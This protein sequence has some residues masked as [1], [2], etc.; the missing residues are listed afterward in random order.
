MKILL[1]EDNVKL[2]NSIQKRLALKNYQVDAF[3]DGKKAHDS[4]ANGYSC[5]VLD[6]NV[7]NIDGI[8]ILKKIR[9]FYSDVPVLIIS[10]TVEL[11]IIKE[12]YD[13]GCN[14]Y[15]K[16]PFFIDE[17]EIKIERL[18][19][20]SDEKIQ[21]D[22]NSFFNYKDSLIII[23]NNEHR[24][25]KKERLLLN[26]FLTQR[27]QVV[28]YDIIENYVWEGAFVSLESIRSLVRRLRKVLQKEY[29]QTVVDTG[30]IFKT[31]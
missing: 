14:D 24:L 1:L 13:F 28:S 10:A 6:I 26:L 9:E 8:K 3:T 31:T 15:L 20:I 11:D 30:Y 17:L 22:T 18:C 5:F 23:E 27:N 19:K 16:K 7:P 25:T 21:F 2:N 12:S 4:I 29:I